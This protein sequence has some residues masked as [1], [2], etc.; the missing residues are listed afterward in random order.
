M[1]LLGVWERVIPA[2]DPEPTPVVV[3]P[4]PLVDARQEEL[5]AGAHTLRV[6]IEEACTALDASAVR[7]AHAALLSQFGPQAWAAQAGAWA[8]ELEWLS[9]PLSGNERASRALLLG[10]TRGL[11]DAP[12]SLVESVRAAA[13]K[14]AALQ[15]LA[16]HG[17]QAATADGRPAGYLVLLSGEVELARELLLA[18]C[19]ADGNLNARWLGYLGEAA[20]RSGDG[21]VA[22]QAYCRASLLDPG[23]IDQ[24]CL[25]CQPVLELMDL[26][27]ELELSDV[28]LS[29]LAVLA[30]LT[31]KHPLR[32]V[33]AS[34]SSPLAVRL[35]AQLCGYRK[36]RA[37]GA[38]DEA[39]RIASK[40]ELARLAPVGLRELLRRLS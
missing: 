30:E 22:L 5:L 6:R 40:R 29:H 19:E 4:P 37:N 8:D 36:A 31:G 23:N 28:S 38:L 25:T 7:E 24:E 16:A 34:A 33:E 35:A 20:W 14:R 32:E 2:A 13:L 27:D 9:E 39:A 10:A 17:P 26:S 12:R 1:N 15:L 3:P 18:A 11:R 21:F